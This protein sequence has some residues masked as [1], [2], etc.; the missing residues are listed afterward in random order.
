MAQ[1]GGNRLNPSGWIQ[2]QQDELGVLFPIP[3]ASADVSSLI[4]SHSR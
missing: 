4:L 3:A 2:E 1:E